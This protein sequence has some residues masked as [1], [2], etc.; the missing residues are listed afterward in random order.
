M[1]SLAQCDLKR[2]RL[3]A[4]MQI[5]CGFVLGSHHCINDGV[6][7]CHSWDSWGNGVGNDLHGP[8]T[9]RLQLHCDRHGFSN[10][11]FERHVGAEE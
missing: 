2:R 11:A 8:W 3:Q 6:W 4:C 9:L 10:Q 7:G 1:Y 5:P